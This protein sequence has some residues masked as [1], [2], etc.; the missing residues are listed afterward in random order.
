MT[1]KTPKK[2]AKNLVNTQAALAKTTDTAHDSEPKPEDLPSADY[3]KERF[4]AGSIPLQT[5]FANM[6]DLA[7]VGRKA[8]GGAENQTGPEDGFTLSTEGL[9][10]LK[11]NEDKGISVDQDGVAVKV[12][13]GIEFD[14]GSVAVKGGEG[15]EVGE[16]GVA[17]KGG[18]GIEVSQDGVTVKAGRGIEIDG[19]G[20]TLPLGV[21]LKHGTQGLDVKCKLDGGLDASEE[22][23]WVI[24]GSGIIVNSD[25]VGVKLSNDQSGLSTD[26]NKGL[27][28]NEYAWI[29]TM[30]GLHGADF[31]VQ[32]DGIAVFFCNIDTGCVAYVYGRNGKCVSPDATKMNLGGNDNIPEKVLILFPINGE[33]AIAT[34]IIAWNQKKASK[35]VHFKC[36]VKSLVNDDSSIP[37]DLQLISA[38]EM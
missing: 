13:N 25:G 19:G 26:G 21:G 37:I 30:C 31:Y 35:E 14:E 16:T 10:Q 3:L 23:T 15:I 29:R 1:D 28:L 2:K 7:N 18:N 6:I 4:K 33:S 8:V 36:E 24:P 22:G 9:L 11:P 27:A 32:E 17:V 20:V 12:D 38:P 34:Q 5:D